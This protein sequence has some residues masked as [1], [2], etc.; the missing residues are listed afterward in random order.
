[1]EKNKVFDANWYCPACG[2][3][4]EKGNHD[5]CSKMRQLKYQQGK[6]VKKIITELDM[7][8]EDELKKLVLEQNE[9]LLTVSHSAN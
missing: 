2:I 8:L 3:K 4:R 7:A 9:D 5:K 1:L 6:H